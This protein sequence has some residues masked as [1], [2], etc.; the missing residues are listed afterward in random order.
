MSAPVPTTGFAE[1]RELRRNLICHVLEGGL[2]IGGL[3]F[4]HGSTVLPR[5]LEQL[6]AAPWLVALAPVLLGIGFISPGLFVAHRIE[7]LE[8]MRGWVVQL[9]VWQRLPYLLAGLALL[10]AT[11]HPLLALPAVLLSP[12]VSGLIGGVAV[13][14]WKE[15]VASAIPE[16]LRASMW[17]TR[18]VL[19]TVLGLGAGGVVSQVLARAPGPR[20]YAYL[21]LGTFVCLALSFVIFLGTS[22]RPRRSRPAQ[23]SF[24]EFVRGIPALVASDRRF[25]LFL[26]ARIPVHAAYI[27]VPFLGIHALGVLNKPDAYLGSLLTF[28][29][30]GSLVGFALAGYSGDRHGGKL[31]MLLAHGGW[32]A[33]AALTPFARESYQFQ[34]LFAMLGAALS[35]SAVGLSTLDLE[36]TPLDRRVSFQAILGAFTLLGMVGS[37]LLSAFI[38]EL[39]QDIWALCLPTLLLTLISLGLFLNIEEPRPRR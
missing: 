31:S 21:H 24:A 26:W 17:A 23:Q 12:L 14:A 13:N 33:V 36:I 2:Y 35:L 8:S 30:L 32:L 38:R 34:A 5:A 9:G 6:G 3:S 29:M 7:R 28:N 1:G 27:L 19:G 37:S 22:E 11:Q 20:G 4:V 16:R 18:Y 10:S 39:T 25:Q 15:Y